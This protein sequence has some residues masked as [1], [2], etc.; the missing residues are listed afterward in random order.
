M[1][2]LQK[3]EVKTEQG[4]MRKNRERKKDKRKDKKRDIKR[5]KWRN[6]RVLLTKKIF[7]KYLKVIFCL[8]SN[9]TVQFGLHEWF[10][11]EIIG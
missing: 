8:L 2:T 6:K 1:I 10:I 7:K 11:I 3:K 9:C 4:L 5:E